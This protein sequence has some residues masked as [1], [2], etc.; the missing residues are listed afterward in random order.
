MASATLDAPL[1]RH[2]HSSGPFSGMP[3]LIT[4]LEQSQISLLEPLAFFVSWQGVLT[5]AFK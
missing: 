3:R 2:A 5:L 1:K 4:E